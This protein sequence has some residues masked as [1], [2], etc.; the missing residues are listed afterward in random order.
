MQ[1]YS[2]GTN[3]YDCDI[4]KLIRRRLE[5]QGAA[6]IPI[7]HSGDLEPGRFVTLGVES[8]AEL[9]ALS[10]ALAELM[11]L[12]MRYFEIAALVEKLAVPLKDKQRILSCAL[13]FTIPAADI[14]KASEG[15]LFYLGESHLLILEGYIRF[16]LQ[17]AAENWSVL[18]D[19]AV[20][21]AMLEEEWSELTNLLGLFSLFHPCEAETIAVILNPDG[22]CTLSKV[23]NDGGEAPG[24]RIDCAPDHAESVLSMLLG[25]RPERI[26]LYDFSFGRAEK[27][28]SCIERV[29]GS[30]ISHNNKKP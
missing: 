7:A 8:E 17:D 25:M 10:A 29:F 26:E 24:F 30:I 6:A 4:E 20:E 2:I 22:S 3:E 23:L 27:L 11:L 12:D 1:L 5:K 18:V 9:R 16:R 14:E 13:R 28:R 21:E 19:A 15:I